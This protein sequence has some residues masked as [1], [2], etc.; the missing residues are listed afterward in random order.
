MSKYVN[1]SDIWRTI[2]NTWVRN[3][4]L[5]YKSFN[6]YINDAG[7]WRGI[8][9]SPYYGLAAYQTNG[10][11]YWLKT[12]T[13]GLAFWNIVDPSLPISNPSGK[14]GVSQSFTF[15]VPS[16]VSQIRVR[17]WGGGGSSGW[18]GQS[19]SGSGGGG[20]Y[21]DCNINVTSG[22]TFLIRVGGGGAHP[23]P[24]ST[25]PR[26]AV[27]TAGVHDSLFVVFNT[28]NTATADI[29]FLGGVGG[30][31][32]G[33]SGIFDSTGSTVYAVA[34]GGGGG[35]GGGGLFT[36]TG[37]AAG[38]GGAAGRNGERGIGANFYGNGG[39]T[40]TTVAG[41]AGGSGGF[42]YTPGSSGGFL[43]GGAG[44]N[45]NYDNTGTN[46]PNGGYAGG[47]FNGGGWGGCGRRR[48]SDNQLFT[49]ADCGGGGGGGYYG[50]GGGQVGGSGGGGG[51][52]GGSNYV[53]TSLVASTNYNLNGL[54]VLPGDVYN[55]GLGAL[56]SA[57]TLIS[58]PTTFIFSS[59]EISS[60]P[61]YS[62]LQGGPGYGGAAV[63]PTPGLPS[64]PGAPG[65]GTGIY[66]LEWVR[67]GNRGENGL[68][69]ITW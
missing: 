57:A 60:V 20:G 48:T 25:P 26:D 37:S 43:F 33:Y 4:G 58:R 40:G 8:P 30:C 24:T 32:G 12:N 41:G 17:L 29:I 53:N 34:G 31:G 1:D 39:A 50:G 5:W 47:G 21:V 68:V 35:G 27:K 6:T 15:T 18:S 56:T 69:I 19:T 10:T 16:G 49:A 3:S 9:Q 28:S 63:A 2:Q 44:G 13:N 38:N 67:I 23:R 51:G 45:G 54:G 7:T 52:G 36:S 14:Y 64:G 59:A 65:S 22:Q 66:E 55:N 46:A 62:F 42:G 61:Q 11:N